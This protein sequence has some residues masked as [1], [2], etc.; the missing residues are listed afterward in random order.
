MNDGH[1]ALW[2]SKRQHWNGADA[3]SRDP[4]HQTFQLPNLK[5]RIAAEVFAGLAEGVGIIG[6]G[7]HA[8]S[9]EMAGMIEEEHAI[10]GHTGHPRPPSAHAMAKAT[11]EICIASYRV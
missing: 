4:A 7:N 3:S 1:V 10:V 6:T 5:R 9:D 2:L 11:G 8:R